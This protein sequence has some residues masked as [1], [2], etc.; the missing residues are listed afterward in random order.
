MYG[1]FAT[2]N[3]DYFPVFAV[4]FRDG[5]GG[6]AFD[7]VYDAEIDQA[8][9]FF[10]RWVWQDA[11]AEIYG[12]LN[13]NDAKYNLRD[14]MLDSD[15]A[16]AYTVGVQKVFQKNPSSKI[17]KFSYE[18]TRIATNLIKVIKKCRQLVFA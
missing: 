12:E 3:R 18:R 16:R 7:Y 1:E 10:G 15:H 14:L 17:Y 13:Y 11:K 4:L 5:S 6:N 9:G 2:K 8:A